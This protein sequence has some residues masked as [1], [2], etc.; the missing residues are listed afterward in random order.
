MTKFKLRAIATTALVASFAVPG[1][2][3]AQMEDEIIVTAQKRE[4]TLQDTPVAVTAVTDTQLKKS[5]IRDM[6]DMPLLATSLSV[7]Q[8]ASSSQTVF[9][10]RGIGTSGFN[11]GLEPSVGVFV[12][13]VY[14]S[15]QGAS[16]NDFPTVERIEVLRGPQSTIYGKNTPAGVIS[17]VT[18]KP[19]YEFGYD[20]EATYA[21][22]DN[23]ILK[24]SVTGPLGNGESAAFRI[25]GN[26]NK[27]DGY[28]DNLFDGSNVNDRD[29]WAVR[30]QLLFE[31]NDNVTVRVIGDFSSINENCCAAPFTFNAPANAAGLTAVGA[32]VL[33][34]D[35]FAR[36]VSFD[37]KLLTDQETA[38]LSTQIDV[39][40]GGVVLTSI[41]AVR[42]LDE[43]NDIDADFV[44]VN[45]TDQRRLTD[46][47]STYTQELRLTSTGANSVDWMLGAYYFNQDLKHTNSTAYGTSLRPFLDVATG[48]L[49]SGLEGILGITQGVAPGTFFAGG[50]GLVSSQF[51]Q[52]TE[53]FSAFSSFDIH[54]S[55]Q[56]TITTGLRW[57]TEKKKVVGLV[58]VNDPFSALS[59]AG[60]PGANQVDASFET[61]LLIQGIVASQAAAFSADPNS[62]FF[63]LP[64]PVILGIAGPAI[65]A[66]TTPLVLGALQ[67]FQFFP[68]TPSFAD[69]RTENN[70]SGN[71][72]LAYDWNDS[73]NT[74]ASY[75]RGYKAGGFNLSSSSRAGGRDFKNETS[76]S[77]E[78]GLKTK[79][80][81]NRL[82]VNVAGFMQELKNFQS[83]IFNGATFDLNNAGKVSSDGVEVDAVFA[84]TDDIIFTAAATYLDDQYDSF[85]RGPCTTGDTDPSC[86]ADGFKD[87][88]GRKPGTPKWNVSSTLTH[89][90]TVNEMDGYIRGELRYTSKGNLGGD[91]D[92]NKAQGAYTILNASVGFGKDEDGWQVQFWGR[93][94]ANEDYLQ[95]AF[96]SVGQAGNFSGYPGDPRTYGVT[97]RLFH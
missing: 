9:S 40:F 44:D 25:S 56:L 58:N 83:N 48:G 42:T 41:S 84:P 95:G 7:A 60:A 61:G 55:D 33:P 92:P 51:N 20:A 94:L 80:F 10:I 14:R 57:S 93:N 88:T 31:P 74:Y 4:K 67:S 32:S 37:G 97:L 90:F 72:I 17:I 5:Q 39:D 49:I 28:I 2:V 69:K 8:A 35:P 16:I 15:R 50:Q 96:N 52:S 22:Y 45:L 34:V 71:L 76:T 12:D 89:L 53:S 85:L 13:G 87:F 86:I 64:V 23:K 91:L 47:Y 11:A 81:D 46:V 26:Y 36:D 59:F 73:V 79:L 24:G 70:I 38:G 77:Y 54:A 68:P 62:P 6:R 65:T 19:Q 43:I 78:F 27:R 66:G 63:G 29:R 3:Y 21:K 75:T 82:Q 1:V 30:G 18:K